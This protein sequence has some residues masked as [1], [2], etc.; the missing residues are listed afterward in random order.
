MVGGDTDDRR[1]LVSRRAGNRGAMPGHHLHSRRQEHCGD[2]GTRT[3][4]TR[5]AN[6]ELAAPLR[7]MPSSQRRSG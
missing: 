6:A 2:E 5:L 1:N 3:L 7:G 4:N